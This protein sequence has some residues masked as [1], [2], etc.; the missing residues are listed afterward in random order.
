M[1]GHE[2]RLR[3]LTVLVACLAIGSPALVTAQVFDAEEGIMVTLRPAPKAPMAFPGDLSRRVEA[4]VDQA[5]NE[6]HALSPAGGPAV[7]LRKADVVKQIQIGPLEVRAEGNVR[8]VKLV[9]QRKA[10]FLPILRVEYAFVRLICNPTKEQRIP[11][12][13]AGLKAMK[14]AAIKQLEWLNTRNQVVNGRLVERPAIPDGRAFIQE[15]L[16]VAAKTVVSPSLVKVYQEELAARTAEQKNVALA[17]LASRLD[18]A[19]ILSDEQ[20]DKIQEAVSSRWHEPWA[21]GLRNFNLDAQYFP[22]VP[23]SLITDILNDE[24]RTIWNGLQKIT[25]TSSERTFGMNLSDD[26]LDEAFSDEEALKGD[27]QPEPGPE[28]KP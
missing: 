4:I 24:Q 16:V 27:V 25:F 19:L 7:R 12:A 8:Q 22:M 3:S 15:A 18:E 9:E 10:L 20:R 23:D 21:Q 6:F 17:S 11:I 26:P 5:I 13:R 1:N 28:T 2:I 14:E